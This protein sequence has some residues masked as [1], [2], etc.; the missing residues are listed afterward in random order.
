MSCNTKRSVCTPR[1]VS[2]RG[3]PSADVTPSGCL[4][5]L[6]ACSCRVITGKLRILA[7]YVLIEDASLVFPRAGRGP[8]FRDI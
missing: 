8:S 4:S 6:S 7:F 5:V 1:D 2:K 3:T